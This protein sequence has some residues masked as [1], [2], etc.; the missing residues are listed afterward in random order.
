MLNTTQLAR[1]RISVV[2]PLYNKADSILQTL[3]SVLEQTHRADEI[4]VV[5]D[6]STD[7]GIDKVQRKYGDQVFIIKQSNAG[8]SAARNRGIKAAKGDYIA[9]LDADDHWSPH[10]IEEVQR[11]IKNH[12]EAGLIGTRYQ[13]IDNGNRY[14]NPKIR[15]NNK[16][17]FF[18]EI[19]L[20]QGIMSS[21]FAIAARGDLPFNASTVTMKKTLLDT[22]KGF[23]VGEAMGEDQDLWARAALN[24]SIAYSPKVLGFYNRAADNR[25]CN[26]KPEGTESP[27]SQRLNRYAK[28]CI[29]E[30]LSKDIIDYTAAHLRY[31]AIQNIYAGEYSNAKNLLRDPRCARQWLKYVRICYL[32]KRAQVLQSIKK[33]M[34]LNFL[35]SSLTSRLRS[36]DS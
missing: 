25:A 26:N 21:Y 28:A 22:L 16:H 33:L 18:G 14:S 23:P 19:Y 4:I 30:A 1:K 35:Q 17:S 5:D 20:E 13:Y 3:Q 12:P 8:V 9:F 24:S 31:L 36:I 10:Y 27:F 7:V 32:L 2:I 29:D 15:F 6:G 11:M 34:S